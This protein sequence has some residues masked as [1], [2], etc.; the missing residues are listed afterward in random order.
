[1]DEGS[2]REDVRVAVLARAELVVQELVAASVLDF[3][4]HRLGQEEV[5]EAEGAGLS[6]LRGDRPGRGAEEPGEES[7]RRAAPQER[8]NHDAGSAP[9][10]GVSRARAGFEA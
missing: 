10:D 2:E 5:G 8:S 7:G 1:M 4:E 3:E 6:R 9:V